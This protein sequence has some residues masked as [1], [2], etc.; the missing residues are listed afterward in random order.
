MANERFKD[1]ARRLVDQLP[2]DA[3]WKDLMYRIH[4]RQA[5]EANLRDCEAGR[6]V[7]V[8]VIRAE[9]GLVD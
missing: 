3:S 2:E 1:A 9:H 4:A 6:L 5:I 8:D 7:D